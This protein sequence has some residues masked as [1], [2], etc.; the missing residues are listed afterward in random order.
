[1]LRPSRPMMRPFMSSLGRST[2]DT[3]VSIACSAALRWMASV[4]IC[5]ARGGGRFAGLGLETLDQVRGVA[6]G[7]GL[8][9][10][11]QQVL[12]LVGRQ[13]RHPLQFAAAARPRAARSASRRPPSACSRSRGACSRA[14]SSFSS[15]SAAASRSAELRFVRRR[16]TCSSR[17]VCWRRVSACRSASITICVRLLLGLEQRFLLA[18]LG[19]AFGVA[20]RCARPALRP[21]PTVSAAI[22]F[23][24]RDPIAT[25]APTAT[26]AATLEMTS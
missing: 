12:G 3:V 9:L 2:T 14:R 13:A 1:M 25:T 20:Q 22:R 21:G 15:R 6:P 16:A 5:L 23:R 8:D 19:L 26:N 24:V 11:E 4:T 10:P 17:A 7:V 18:R